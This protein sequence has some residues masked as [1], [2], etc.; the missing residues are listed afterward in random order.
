MVNGKQRY[1]LMTWRN[2]TEQ[3]LHFS[4]QFVNYF[5]VSGKFMNYCYMCLECL[6]TM[7]HGS[8]VFVDYATCVWIVW[9]MLHVSGVFVNYCYM[10]LEC[11]RTVATCVWSVYELLLHV[12]RVFM[13]CCYMCLACFWIIATCVWR[14]CGLFVTCVWSVCEILLH[15]SDVFVNYCYMFWSVCAAGDAEILPLHLHVRGADGQGD[16]SPYRRV[17]GEPDPRPVRDT[18]VQEEQWVQCIYRS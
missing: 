13:Y 18:P 15:V 8:G 9:T 7:L 10:C 11:L 1:S 3:N 17:S 12:F 14:V 16:N 5:H 4:P 6:W 2:W